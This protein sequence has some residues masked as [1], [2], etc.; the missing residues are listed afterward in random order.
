MEVKHTVGNSS[1][2]AVIVYL[3]ADWKLG[4]SWESIGNLV[5]NE[6]DMVRSVDQ[7]IRVMAV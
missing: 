6:E 4:V 2:V 1:A 3:V 5:E 7:R